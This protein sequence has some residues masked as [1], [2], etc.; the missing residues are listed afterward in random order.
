[1]PHQESLKPFYVVISFWLSLG[2]SLSSFLLFV[3]LALVDMALR[4][5][6]ANRSKGY[7]ESAGAAGDLALKFATAGFAPSALACCVVFALI[8]TSIALALDKL[9]IL[10]TAVGALVGP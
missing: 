2:L 5:R 7:Q 4:R 3:Y 10:P 1:M 6:D 8:S 9:S